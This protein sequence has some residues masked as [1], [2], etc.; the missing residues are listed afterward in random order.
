VN[1][2]THTIEEGA[3]GALHVDVYRATVSAPAPAVVLLHG[4]KG[5]RRWGF[6]PEAAQRIAA[7]GLHVV[8]IDVSSNGMRGTS[9]IVID[10]EAFRN[11]TITAD[12]DD[13]QTTLEWLNA[14]GN[15]AAVLDGLWNNRL[16]FVGHSRG[17]ALALLLASQMRS[18][19]APDKLDRLVL[20]NSI[21]TYVRWT[22]RQRNA[23]QTNGSV[24]IENTRTGQKLAMGFQYV[25]DIED[26]A[27]QRDLLAAAR[28]VSDCV[29]FVHAE[30]DVTAS[31]KEIRP[32]VQAT[33]RGDALVTIPNSGHTFGIQHPFGE[34][35]P[36]FESVMDYTLRWLLHL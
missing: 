18:K 20:W 25:V 32:L 35:T 22:P 8:A 26:H 1:V 7:A 12:I 5:F 10:L 19:V 31:V 36:A 16:H 27:Q 6:L 11:Q 23:W 14:Q 34:S 33:G 29:L 17:G 28:V 9:N 21:G 3:L 13:V 15:H 24:E 2:S 4:F 30:Q